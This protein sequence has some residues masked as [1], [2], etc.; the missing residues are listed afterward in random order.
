MDPSL[1]GRAA[2]DKGIF[3]VTSSHVFPEFSRMAQAVMP[4]FVRHIQPVDQ[5]LPID[6]TK[7]DFLRFVDWIHLNR[8]RISNGSKT[9]IQVRRTAGIDYKYT[10]Y[11]IKESL[12]PFLLEAGLEPVVQN[13]DSVISIFLGQSDAYLGISKPEEN[14]SD[15]PGGAIRFRRDDNQT[16]R[17]RFKLE[18]AFLVFQ[19]PVETCREALDL[20]SA[21][22]GWTSFLL[23]CGLHVTAVDTGQMESDLLRHPNLT[24][25]QANSSEVTFEPDSFDIITCDMSWDPIHTA[26]IVLNV[27]PCLRKDG[28]LLITIKLMHKKILKTIEG[29]LRVLE[30]EFNLKRVKQLFH[31]RDEVTAYLIKK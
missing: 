4:I 30:P 12:D 11:S 17:S 2:L 23:D 8:N 3:R 20:G 16:S 21:P 27:A 18:E 31:N 13:P 22:G 5:I 25:I 24:F 26:N 10:P 19:I 29:F 28:I 9:A 1:A 6:R 7:A 15:W 14:L